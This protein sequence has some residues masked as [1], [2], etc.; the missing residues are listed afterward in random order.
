MARNKLIDPGTW[1]S[2]GC[3]RRPTRW[4]NWVITPFAAGLAVFVVLAAT[5]V[6]LDPW[7][8]GAIF[9]MGMMTLAFLTVGA[10]P[11]SDPVHPSPIDWGL[12]LVSLATGIFFAFTADET[13]ARISLLFP[14]STWQT[15][16][17]TLV[18]A[19]T[20]EI[21]RRT[22]GL[23]L[24]MIVLLFV[25]YNFFGHL[26]G[27][28]LGHNYIDYNHFL[29]IMIFTTDGVMGLPVQVAATYAFLF[30]MFGTLMFSRG[31]TS[32]SISP[33]PSPARSPAGR[34]R[35]RWCLRACTA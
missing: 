10:C 11:D 8:L 26:L 32:S 34:P 25:A 35:S 2:V 16:F 9:L 12:S 7:K 33:P 29:D 22:T 15:V 1:F 30:V 4:L 18:F 20:M 14:L 23:G 21:T 19:L 13:V 31:P 6:I 27:G 24:T 3:R 5:V 17:G 28:V